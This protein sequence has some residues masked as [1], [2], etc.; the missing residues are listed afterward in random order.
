[1]IHTSLTDVRQAR[2][3]LKPSHENSKYQSWRYNQNEKAQQFERHGF[4]RCTVCQ[5][6]RKSR[7]NLIARKCADDKTAD[8]QTQVARKVIER[9]GYGVYKS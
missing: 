7:P 9:V 8:R 5:F 1:M 2:G 3:L 4:E 6:L